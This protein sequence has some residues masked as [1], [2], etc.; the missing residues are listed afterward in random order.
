MEVTFL[1][2]KL[3]FERVFFDEPTLATMYDSAANRW[4]K[5]VK[6]MGYLEAYAQLFAGLRQT[7]LLSH[8]AQNSTILDAGIGTGALS[9]ALLEHMPD[10]HLHGVDIAPQMLTVAQAK[11]KA[12]GQFRQA[13]ITELPYADNSF[14]MVMSAHV[15]EHISDP[16]RGFHEVLRILKQGQPFVIVATR[17]CLVTRVL[18]LKWNFQPMTE[19]SVTQML[20]DAGATQINIIPL[21]QSRK[22]TRMSLVYT[23]IKA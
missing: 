2:W 23:G 7:P 10:I 20:I 9:S 8:L 14:D 13:S 5:S 22:M 18:S 11:L 21:T 15:L 12:E 6:R 1:N 17:V 19:N 4:E 3:S 16:T